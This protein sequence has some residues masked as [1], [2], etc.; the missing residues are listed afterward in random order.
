[1]PE[2]NIAVVGAGLVG[3]RHIAAISQ[4]PRARL[5]AI[6]DTERNALDY[7]AQLGVPCYQQLSELW[8]GQAVDGIILATPTPAH[9]EQA[10]LCIANACPTLIEKPIATNSADAR[11]LVELSQ[12]RRV[13]LLV[14]HHRRYNPLIAAARQAIESGLLGELRALTATCWFYKPDAYFEQAPWRKELGAGPISV[15]LAHDIDLIRY[16]C[17]EVISVQAQ[18]VPARRGYANEDVAAAILSFANGALGTVTVADAVVSPWSWELTAGEY[19]IYSQTD[20]FCYCIGGSAGALSIPDMKLWTHEQ[21]P[22]WWTPIAAQSLSYQAA[23]PLVNQIRHFVEVIKGQA[24][25]LVSGYEGWKTLEVVEAIQ[26]S[27][28]SGE[29]VFL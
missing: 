8:R 9:A 22:D 4:V 17:G 12:Q 23:D 16:L 19:P 24:Q 7:S 27:A 2:I 10:K 6:V 15:N 28:R 26:S 25:P 3:K 29:R 11:A 14:G 1:M 20:Q 18:A 5:C 21:S 13:P